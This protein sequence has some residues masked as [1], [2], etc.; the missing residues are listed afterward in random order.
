MRLGGAALLAALALGGCANGSS[1]MQ[2]FDGDPDVVTINREAELAYESG[3]AAKAEAL[4]KS[5][6]RRMPND[7]ETWFRLGNLYARANRPDEAANAYQ[8]ALIA[9]N[10]NARAWH[11]LSVIRLRQAW[12][13][14]LQA[15]DNLKPDSPLYAEV[16]TVLKQL[17]QI[18]LVDPD[19]KN[20]PAPG[21]RP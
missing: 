15:H 18:R 16:E 11:N 20:A 7:A 14:M 8:R 12:A 9:N 13:A 21:T 6:A 19:G 1:P 4:Y 3:D 10:T 17:E 2:M 5:L